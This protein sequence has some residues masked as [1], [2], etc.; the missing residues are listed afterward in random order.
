MKLL[1]I[2]EP[3]KAVWREAPMP[4]P[5]SGEVLVK[6]LGVTTCPHW[7]L[8]IMAGIPMFPDRP[9]SY[10][11]TPGEP[12][13]EAMGEVVAVQSGVK[14]FAAGMRVVV[15]RDPGGRRQGCYA[16]YVAL[17]AENLIAIPNSLPPE[18]IA[19]LELAMCVQGSINKLQALDGVTGKRVAVSG[20]GPA[21]LIAVQMSRA[22]GAREVIGID[23]LS[24]RLDLAK[25]LGADVVVPPGDS[26]L[27]SNRFALNSFDAALDTTG[28]KDSIETLMKGTN[29]A[30]AI[31][32]V[33]REEV[34]FGPAQWWGG[35][36]LLGYGTHER[37]QAEQALRLIESGQLQL[38]PLVTH[39][40]P[41]TRY[42]E[43]VDLL[44][45]KKAIKILF[46]PW[47]DS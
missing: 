23:P 11:Y 31:F 36:A 29:G 34:K 2:E 8:H 3:G 35:F 6:I 14:D 22:Y 37:S 43:G 45:R 28:I 33:L 17:E 26:K 10:P 21:G 9:L 5:A 16:Q 18:S 47:A 25:Q 20:L 32:G 27:P 39:Q 42:A 30:V 19:S 4:E 1:Q 24:D 41:F 40:L 38:S 15:W 12:G 7:D 13:H 44:R 46:L